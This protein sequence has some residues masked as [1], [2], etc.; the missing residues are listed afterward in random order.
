MVQVRDGRGFPWAVISED[1]EKQE[2]WRNALE[3]EWQDMLVDLTWRMRESNTTLP[4]WAVSFTWHLFTLLASESVM[5]QPSSTISMTDCTRETGIFYK[6]Q[7]SNG[8]CP[9]TLR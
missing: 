5:F 9:D 2:V 8:P 6:A 3:L 4:F 7:Q 1:G